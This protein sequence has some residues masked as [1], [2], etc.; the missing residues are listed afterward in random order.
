MSEEDS[1][2][3]TVTEGEPEKERSIPGKVIQKTGEVLH[4]AADATIFTERGNYVD[5][6]TEFDGAIANK[7]AGATVF[8][9]HGT[10]VDGKMEFDGAIAK[11]IKN[12]AT[13][14]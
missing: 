11:D 1:A 12:K 10:N 3:A 6:K 4:K 5:G 2:N 7:V 9:E 8:S 14:K 13:G